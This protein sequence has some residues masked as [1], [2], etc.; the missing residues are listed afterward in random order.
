MRQ[1]YRWVLVST[2][3]FTA[4][5]TVSIQA[6]PISCEIGDPILETIRYPFATVVTPDLI[7]VTNQ[8]NGDV[9]SR[10]IYIETADMLDARVSDSGEWVAYTR[11]LPDRSM[12]LWLTSVNEPAP[13]LVKAFEAL[14]AMEVGGRNRSAQIAQ[15]EWTPGQDV[16]I[17]TDT[18][19][20]E[21]PIA[22]SENTLAVSG[23]FAASA[24]GHYLA[25]T[26]LENLYLLDFEH[27]LDLQSIADSEIFQSVAAGIVYPQAHWLPDSSAFLRLLPSGG[28]TVAIW[29][30]TV[31]GDAEMIGSLH[32]D[33]FS[34]RFSPT[35]EHLV[36][37]T[38]SL[39]N[40][41]PL[42]TVYIANSD[43]TNPVAILTSPGMT[44]H[45]WSPDGHHLLTIWI[46]Q[47]ADALYTFILYVAEPHY[48]W[49]RST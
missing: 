47:K 25:I 13:R 9:S 49:R 22:K 21:V 8:Q 39:E 7:V 31:A 23:Y 43:G 2:L 11:Y 28:D 29:Q 17:Y 46:T 48:T 41:E 42:V 19:L 20:V 24:N 32:T 33:Y 5:F 30:Y 15:W 40:G 12:E 3:V 6:Q 14:P 16:L 1:R 26:G 45:E 10:D 27:E 4:F 36:F 38:Q 18:D 34:V 37:W 35:M 44:F